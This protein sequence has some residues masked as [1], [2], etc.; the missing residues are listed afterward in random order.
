MKKVLF[1]ALL[2]T[3]FFGQ[4]QYTLIPDPNF[5]QALSAYD[6]KPGD[7]HIPTA[8][9]SGLKRLDVSNSNISSLSGIEAFISLNILFVY[10]N[11][12]TSIDVSKNKLLEILAIGNNPLSN[13]D[14]SHNVALTSFNCDYCPLKK[15]DLSKNINLKWLFCGHCNLTN[16][17]LFDNTDLIYLE[18][19]SNQLKSLDLSKTKNIFYVFCASNQLR[20]LDLS[21]LSYLFE[22]DCSSNQLTN[23]ILPNNDQN[24]FFNRLVFSKLDC[25]FNKL[26][27]I[28]LTKQTA[29]E[30]FS[31]QNNNLSWLSIRNGFNELINPSKLDLKSNPNLTCILVDNKAYS[32]ANWSTSKDA[33]A[34]F[35][36]NCSAVAITAPVLTS[37]G[38]QVYCP[39]TNQKIVTA[40]DIAHDPSDTET[41][42][43]Y[44][45]IS[46]GYVNGQDVLQLEG[47]HPTITAFWDATA[48]KLTLSS[49]TVGTKVTYTDFVSAIKDVTFSNSSTAPSGSRSFSISLG[50]A[51]YLPSTQHYYLFVPDIGIKWTDAKVIAGTST[52][53]GLHG[54]L[55]TLTA[56]DEA[57]FA[58]EQA[59]GA[60]WIGGSDEET[61]DVWKW[62]TGPEA[63][64]V[65]W[66]GK[67]NGSSPNFAFWNTQNIN[68]SEPN[69]YQKS[70]E[71]YAHI[72]ASGVGKAGSW[73]DLPDAGYPSGDYQ[74]K[75]YIVEYGGTVGDPPAP[76]IATSTS[77]TIPTITATDPVAKCDSGIF[78]LE[79]TTTGGTIDWYDQDTGGTLLNTGTSYTT[80]TLTTTTTYYVQTMGCTGARTKISA[81]INTTPSLPIVAKP[82]VTTCG[83]G[84]VTLEATTTA[85]VINWYDVTTGGTLLATG[86]KY[87]IPNATQ[88]KIYY[89][90][91]KNGECI[92]PTRVAVEVRV[93]TPPVVTDENDLVLCESESLTLDAKLSGLSYL[94]NTGE[95]GQTI[96][97]KKG[98]EYSVKITTAAP[99][100][101]S[102]TKKFMVIEHFIPKIT[103]I[104][105]DETTVTINLEKPASYYEYSIN[106]EDYQ[107]SNVFY[108]VSG[109]LQKGYVR[110]IN[111]NNSDEKSFVV[112]AAPKFFTP[113]NDGFNDVWEIKGLEKFPQASITIFDRYGKLLKSMLSS[114]PFWDGTFNK[115]PLPAADYWYVLK[116]DNS[117]ERKGHFSLKR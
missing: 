98:G 63:G 92:N 96:D 17:D 66:N 46:S 88:N 25:G 65:F 56:L 82:L 34:S 61:D 19:D 76:Q 77:I 38:N 73:N 4:A 70:G 79:A 93:Y 15:L 102:A 29:I 43:L 32:D 103:D 80:P 22:I 41:D 21:T 53:Y 115:E 86:T 64:T 100:S 8:N 69:D 52:Y 106:G 68:D 75:G 2:F 67:G 20:T 47:S 85:G 101:C 90:E 24:N 11:N 97:V 109:G 42:A 81:T 114:K 62:V 94:W 9:V 59:S 13:F 39:K 36:E 35:S 28:D 116:I 23:L 18:C 14:L 33:T 110:E 45:Q 58:G 44:V 83:P 112:I 111:C 57:K 12:L 99:E 40:F 48:G 5:E 31:C 10:N 78:T 95:M 55:A 30:Y 3:S 49:P 91:S 7:Y 50:Q 87:E 60:G 16:L 84:A 105:V 113:N 107:S 108:E 71:K 27:S 37:A 26:T 89:A 6:D 72:T 51:N 74:P 1:F 117:T 104:N 54:Y